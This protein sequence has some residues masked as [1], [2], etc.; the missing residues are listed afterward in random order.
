M[1]LEG[2]K[3]KNTRANGYEKVAPAIT[4]PTVPSKTSK[5]E[6]SNTMNPKKPK[7]HTL[8]RH[9]IKLA[10]REQY[11]SR[12]FAQTRTEYVLALSFNCLQVSRE[13]QCFKP[14]PLGWEI[15]EAISPGLSHKSWQCNTKEWNRDHSTTAHFLIPEKNPCS[16][17]RASRIQVR[18]NQNS[19]VPLSSFISCF[20][21]A[22]TTKM[23]TYEL[24]Q[25]FILLKNQNS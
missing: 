13:S 10:S 3:K 12:S 25:F 20:L 14:L 7:E 21:S 1:H 5:L 9:H 24:A 18:K 16:H 6:A 2:K 22:L 17:L 15:T 11:K 19:S 23:N 8:P 4:T